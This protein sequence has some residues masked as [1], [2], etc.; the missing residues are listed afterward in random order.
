[1]IDL[2]HVCKE[3][4]ILGNMPIFDHK[5]CK[6]SIFKSRLTQFLCEVND[7]KE[8]NKS[9]VLITHLSDISYRLV[10][11]LAYPE[12]L[13]VLSLKKLVELLDSH[14]KPKHCTFADKAKFYAATR[15]PGETLGDWAARLRGLASQCDFGAALDTNLTDRFV[16]GLGLRSGPERDKV[17]EQNASKL[18]LSRALEIAEQAESAREAKSNVYRD[19]DVGIK[20]EAVYKVTCRGC[21]SAR[22]FVDRNTMLQEIRIWLQ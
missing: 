13:E 22:Y 2:T 8:D 15:N 3:N 20:E 7:V 17:F 4:D 16:V 5:L 12:D 6:W 10:R 9:A 21:T 1:M 14:F 11:N 19:L 18:S